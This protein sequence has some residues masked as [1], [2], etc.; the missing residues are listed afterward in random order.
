[1]PIKFKVDGFEIEVADVNAQS[2]VE[3]AIS[4]AR[5]DADDKLAVEKSRADQASKDLDAAKAKTT[6]LQAKCDTLEAAAKV[7]V[8]CDE[9]D[10]SGKVGEKA[11]MD[12]DGKGQMKEDSLL[13]FDR[14]KASR[15]R[16]DAAAASKAGSI[17]AKLL[18]Q[19]AEHLSAN[20]KLDG[21]TDVDIKKLILSKVDKDLKL[22]GRDDVY[23]SHRFD[24]EMEQYSKKKGRP[25]D[26]VRL[27]TD[28]TPKKDEE[29]IEEHVD[30]PE[31]ARAVMQ[32]RNALAFVKR[33]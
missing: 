32:K 11:C 8:K 15:A 1:M 28:P 29:E 5:K 2:I 19:A 24:F 27:V 33:R 18:L 6:E 25:I 4:G 21:K 31:D 23:V 7:D 22:D 17:R 16:S 10:G 26:R 3:R 30:S 12:C 13:D 14:R 9:C 20:E